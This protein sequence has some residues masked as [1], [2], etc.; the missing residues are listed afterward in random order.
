MDKVS[1]RSEER[2]QKEAKTTDTFN[3]FF[4]LW[5][6]TKFSKCHLFELSQRKFIL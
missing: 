2:H 6:T 5:Q 1:C 4:K 3:F